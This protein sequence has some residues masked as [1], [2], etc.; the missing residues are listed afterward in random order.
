MKCDMQSCIRSMNIERKNRFLPISRVLYSDSKPELLSFIYSRPHE[1]DVSTYPLTFERVTLKG[2][3]ALRQ[4][5][6]YFNPQGLSVLNIAKKDR[7]LLL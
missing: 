5:T 2:F 1:R 4:H 3:T 6:W 7:A